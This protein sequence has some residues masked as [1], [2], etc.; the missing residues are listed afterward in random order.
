MQAAEHA[1]RQAHDLDR[2][3]D[4]R[5]AAVDGPL[6]RFRDRDGHVYGALVEKTEGPAVPAS[7]GA[8]P[9]PQPVY[10][11]RLV[12]PPVRGHERS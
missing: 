10:R 8:A 6:V 2:I 9:E 7:C 1:I 12:E 11:A 4:L 3:E 5:L